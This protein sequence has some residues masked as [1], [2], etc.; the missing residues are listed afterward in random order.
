MGTMDIVVAGISGLVGAFMLLKALW[1][2]TPVRQ[3][4]PCKDG[5]SPCPEKASDA[6]LQIV[7]E[8]SAEFWCKER[9]EKEAM[10]E[11]KIKA[12]EEAA[13]APAADAGTDEAM[14]PP[15]PEK[16][17]KLEKADEKVE[18]VLTE[19]GRREMIDTGTLQEYGSGKLKA[20]D[21]LEKSLVN[22]LHKSRVPSGSALD[23]W[24]DAKLIKKAD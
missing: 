6:H 7:F 3:R 14:R 5:E 16:M 8:R 23:Y 20:Y 22:M 13:A 10:I 4:A 9:G 18:Y 2:H 17:K 24:L 21:V 15:K 11:E 19:A 1:F 12:H